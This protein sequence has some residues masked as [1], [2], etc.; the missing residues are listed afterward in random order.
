MHLM[1]PLLEQGRTVYLDNWYSSPKLFITLHNKGT[2]A[3]GTVRSNRVGLPKDINV[4]QL[5]RGEMEV[6]QLPPLTYIVWSDKLSN[7]HSRV[8][9]SDPKTK[10]SIFKSN[11]IH[12]YN[13]NMGGVDLVDQVTQAY[14]S[15][16]KTIKWYK[17]LFLHILDITIYNSLVVWRALNPQKRMSYLEFRLAIVQSLIQNH[18]VER[19][20]HTGGRKSRQPA[21]LRLKQ[22]HF[23]SRIPSKRKKPQAGG[24]LC[25]R[26]KESEKK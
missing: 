26:A 14:P 21:L 18:H 17:K 11:L 12:E 2:N 25:V 4:K 23:P 7:C 3:C 9:M 13:K 19:P 22:K 8:T 16:R 5:Q 10:M 6:R 20:L 15:M 24:V 1:Q